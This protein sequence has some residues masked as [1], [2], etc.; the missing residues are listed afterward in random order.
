[1]MHILY[2]DAGLRGLEGHLASSG[3][4]LPA[5]F[6][7]LGHRVTVLG[8][9]DLVPALQETTGAVPFF[10]A[11]TWGRWSD[12]PLAGWLIDFPQ[13]VNQTVADLHLAW[14]EFG[15]F[16]L[17]YVNTARPAQFAAAAL[18]LKEA[19]PGRVGAPAV[20]V[21]LGADSGLRRSG[22]PH[23]PTF[24][25]RDPTTVLH[26]FATHW[27][28]KEWIE[29]L[30]LVAVNQIVAGE[31]SFLVD[32][33]VKAMPTPEGLPM[34]RLRERREP[35]T[36]GLLGQQRIDKG[37]EFLPD[38]ILR[39]LGGDPRVRFIVQHS[40]PTGGAQEDRPR[41]ERTTTRLCELAAYDPRVEIILKPVVGDAWFELIDR[42]D[43]VALP[44]D[45]PRYASSYSAIFGEALASG[46]VIV[47]PSGTT[48]S[49]ELDEAGGAGTTF[50]QWTAAAVA[51]AVG[52]AIDRFDDLRM[53][54][55]QGGTAWRKLH[56]PDAYAAAVIE[57][58]GLTTGV[59]TPVV[60][61]AAQSTKS[62]PL[63]ATFV[64]SP[65]LHNGS[66]MKLAH[67]AGRP[68]KSE[69]WS[70][71]M[72]KIAVIM[73]RD[74]FSFI[75]DKAI[76]TSATQW[77]YAVTADTHIEELRKVP[78]R[79]QLVVE[80]LIEVSA[81]A[82]GVAWLSKDDKLVTI[83]RTVRARRGPQQIFALAPCEQAHRLMIRNV[84]PE[85][86]KAVFTVR[87]FKVATILPGQ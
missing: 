42:C 32:R 10:R 41:M 40:D 12:D 24:E 23:A 61:G 81:G 77:D 43:I 8:H 57:A 73:G 75:L 44:Y 25:L 52:A 87:K 49:K 26:R 6:R 71:L 34:L 20:A 80:M 58:A 2:A 72:G 15:P 69:L 85:D 5:A 78:A 82:I 36:I 28:G 60:S 70:W 37:Y 47:A 11:F 38:L 64:R 51:V 68:R 7:R 76:E 74:Q 66:S 46:A 16:D 17:I 45:P 1:M 21:Q 67:E 39:V 48:I 9:C 19:F 13:V 63:P 79:S 14:T 62:R 22:P 31:Y 29:R 56:G 18:W 4:A 3:I 59:A 35:L 55:Y 54:A 27:V 86:H 30:V 33:P 84:E 50:D 83:E 53:R 65:R